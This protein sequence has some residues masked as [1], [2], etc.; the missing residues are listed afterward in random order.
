MSVTIII[1]V[2][3]YRGVSHVCVHKTT[4]FSYFISLFR[5]QQR[6]L[7]LIRLHLEQ[8]YGLGYK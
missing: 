5:L 1:P 4:M 8:M 3:T 6:W 7:L 2:P